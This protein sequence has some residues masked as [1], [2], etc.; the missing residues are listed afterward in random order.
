MFGNIV[1]HRC[2]INGETREKEE[3]EAVITGEPPCTHITWKRG[4]KA[5]RDE[6]E[7]EEASKVASTLLSHDVSP[8][9]MQ[10]MD[11]GEYSR[12]YKDPT[13]EIRRNGGH[14]FTP[15]LPTSLSFSLLPLL[16]T[17]SLQPLSLSLSPAAALVCLYIGSRRSKSE[18]SLSLASTPLRLGNRPIVTEIAWAQWM[19]TMGGSSDHDHDHDHGDDYDHDGGGCCIAAFSRGGGGRLRYRYKCY[20]SFGERVKGGRGGEGAGK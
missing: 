5:V 10:I 9:C 14:L 16:P 18:P 4:E 1:C 6:E 3:E 13:Q 17:S 15:P 2:I 12:T 19:M 20:V 8:V 11:V 7:E